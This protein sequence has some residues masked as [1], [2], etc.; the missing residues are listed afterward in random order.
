MDTLI[1]KSLK[2]VAIDNIKAYI[3]EHRLQP[4]DPF[5]NEKE[6]IEL[7]GVSRTVVREALKSLE[8]LGILK[9][10][11]GD[12]IFVGSATLA[13]LMDQFYMR[14]FGDT[15]KMVELQEIRTV[16]ELAAIDMVVLRAEDQELEQLEGWNERMEQAIRES[17]PLV[18]LD[19]GF[20]R[21]LFKLT[22]NETFYEFS[23][24]I[25][26]FFTEVRQKRLSVSG[27][28]VTLDDHRRITRCIRERKAAEAKEYM[29]KHLLQSRALKHAG[30][31]GQT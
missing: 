18:E 9:L 17:S 29:L 16:L 28:R 22:G 6:I 19:I 3:V 26:K 21:T 14:W 30:S 1:R 4:G 10:K 11:P 20:H 2:D 23:E 15:K 12:G 25:S 8:T 24:V 5:P 7:L 27:G 31:S 13:P